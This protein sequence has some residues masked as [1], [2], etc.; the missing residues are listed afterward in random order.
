MGLAHILQL[1]L[2][3]LAPVPVDQGHGLEGRVLELSVELLVLLLE[4]A[5]LLGLLHEEARPILLPSN[6]RGQRGK[7]DNNLRRPHHSPST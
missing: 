6:W 1:L 5:T 3:Q 7:S 2:V 4:C